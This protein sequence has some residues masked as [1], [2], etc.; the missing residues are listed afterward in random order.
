MVWQ[1]PAVGKGE[2]PASPSSP[3]CHEEWQW[4]AAD[5]YP[6]LGDDATKCLDEIGLIV[7]RFDQLDARKKRAFLREGWVQVAQ[8]EMMATHDMQESSAPPLAIAL[9]SVLQALLTQKVYD[10]V[11][12]SQLN[13][14]PAARHR[15]LKDGRQYLA[16]WIVIRECGWI[17]W[18]LVKWPLVALLEFIGS[19]LCN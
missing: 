1:P 11:V 13:D 19:V 9:A 15:A 4:T 7:S 10:G 6:D 18:S 5:L 17:V 16:T 3:T 12:R 8:T 14:L 2:H